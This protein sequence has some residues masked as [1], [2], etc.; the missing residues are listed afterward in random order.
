MRVGSIGFAC[1]PDATFAMLDSHCARKGGAPTRGPTANLSKLF[2]PPEG[3]LVR[4]PQGEALSFNEAVAEALRRRKWLL[5]NVQQGSEFS[6]HQLNRDCWSNGAIRALVQSSFV[7]HQ[8]DHATVDGLRYRNTYRPPSVPSIAILDPITKQK[9]WDCH[10]DVA[11]DYGSAALISPDALAKGEIIV[12]KRFIQR[13]Q[14]VLK[15]WAARTELLA[16]APSS[17]HAAS[18]EERMLQA[19]IQASMETGGSGASSPALSAGSSSGAAAAASSSSSH[20]AA[21]PAASR[22]RATDS[23]HPNGQAKS[24]PIVLDDSSHDEADDEEYV[25]ISD[26]DGEL[27]ARVA[28]AGGEE[29]DDDMSSHASSTAAAAAAPAAA[30]AAASHKRKRQEQPGDDTEEHKVRNTYG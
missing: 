1:G 28:R 3:L 19:A 27:D 24:A 8:I 29:V 7:F 10:A 15:E 14:R 25:Q 4:G 26:S 12:G 20:A 6:T 17:S 30:A 5:V 23:R 13:M 9:M 21:Q 22:R 11:E 2:A 18:E 16:D